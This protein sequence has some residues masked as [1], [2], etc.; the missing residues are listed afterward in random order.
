MKAFTINAEGNITAFE[1]KEAAEA[2]LPPTGAFVFT[3]AAGLQG[4]LKKFPAST[5]V[6]IWNSLTGVTQVKS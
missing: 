1:S 4:Y 6:E 3:A 5:P 2:N